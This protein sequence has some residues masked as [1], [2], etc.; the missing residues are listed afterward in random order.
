MCFIIQLGGGSPKIA[1]EDIVVYKT[2]QFDRLY[3]IGENC[4]V[5][6]N[7]IKSNKD[8]KGFISKYYDFKYEFGECYY[9]DAL[10]IKKYPSYSE[11]KRGLHSFADKE[12]A[13][14]YSSGYLIPCIIP[15]GA[16]YYYNTHTNNYISNYLVI[17]S[18]KEIKNF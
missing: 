3:A 14:A 8:I 16:T 2:T 7:V 5:I 11:L 13:I 9:T 4:H 18:V 12:T 17:G 10:E 1:K 6:K 15:K